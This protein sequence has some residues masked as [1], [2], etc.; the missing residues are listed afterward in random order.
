MRGP[1][2]VSCQFSLPP[3]TVCRPVVPAL[4]KPCGALIEH[5]GLSLLVVFFLGDQN[6][7]TVAYVLK[8]KTQIFK[9]LIFAM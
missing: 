4:R 2:V 8:N 9:K 3:A 1:L 6:T 7:L 5:P